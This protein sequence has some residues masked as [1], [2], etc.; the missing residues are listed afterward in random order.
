MKN[1]EQENDIRNDHGRDSVASQ[2]HFLF[3]LLLLLSLFSK[4]SPLLNLGTLSQPP[5]HAYLQKK[6]HWRPWQLAQASWFLHPK[7]IWGPKRARG[8]PRRARVQ[9]S[10]RLAQSIERPFCPSFFV[11]FTFLIKTLTDHLFCI[12]TG[13]QHCTSTNKDQKINERQFP[14]EIRYNKQ[15]GHLNE[16]SVLIFTS[17][18]FPIIDK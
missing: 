5:L 15:Q 6:G 4:L 8:Q 16:I 11:F 2:L 12:V 13:I 1:T 10:Q 18:L 9:A 14:D 3:F 7:V 17:L